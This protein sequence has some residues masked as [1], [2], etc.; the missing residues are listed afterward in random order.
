MKNSIAVIG[1]SLAAFVAAA[2]YFQSSLGTTPKQQNGPIE[3]EPAFQSESSLP[4]IINGA[5]EIPAQVVNSNAPAFLDTPKADRPLQDGFTVTAL[6]GGAYTQPPSP[7]VPMDQPIP[8]AATQRKTKTPTVITVTQRPVA[9]PISQSTQSIQ[10][11]PHSQSGISI[12]ALTAGLPAYDHSIYENGNVIEEQNLPTAESE[13]PK[14]DHS[15]DIAARDIK[16][17]EPEEIYAAMEEGETTEHFAV[18]LLAEGLR[19]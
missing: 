1:L 8:W 14:H 2:P 4:N 13:F 5:P 12:E 6:H 9:S 7:P 11:F 10:W 15:S 3:Q 16:D 17:M 18:R 19:L